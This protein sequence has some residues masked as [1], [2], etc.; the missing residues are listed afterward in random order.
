MKISIKLQWGWKYYWHLQFELRRV[1]MQ[2]EALSLLNQ[3]YLWTK[4]TSLG[5]QR[6]LC[7]QA[8]LE[9]VS[10]QPLF[11]HNTN[12][13]SKLQTLFKAADEASQLRHQAYLSH[14]HRYTSIHLKY[15]LLLKEKPSSDSSCSYWFEI[16]CLCTFHAVTK[17]QS[18][19]QIL[20]KGCFSHQLTR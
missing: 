3:K 11:H 2:R 4:G 1:W 10:G 16:A 18:H 12:G 13:L 20:G 15:V 5:I 9:M 17:W 7:P 14:K 6:Q 19:M 8:A